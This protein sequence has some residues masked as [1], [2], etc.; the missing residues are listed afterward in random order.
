MFPTICADVPPRFVSP[1]P[2]K[3]IINRDKMLDV[4]QTRQTN[5]WRFAALTTTLAAVVGLVSCGSTGRPGKTVSFE[6]DIA[7]VLMVRCLECHNSVDKDKNAGLILETRK[8]AMT[9]GRSIPVIRPGD[10]DG[11]V[12]YQ[13]LQLG[14]AHQMAM[15]PSPDKIWGEQLDLIHAWIAQGADWPDDVVLKRPQDWAE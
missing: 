7:P 14:H 10:P 8:L 13:V 1:N 6:K 4:A 3:S 5:L 9:T 2:E 15:P 12:F 11:S